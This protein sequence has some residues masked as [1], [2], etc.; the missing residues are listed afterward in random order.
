[1]L[2]KK[3]F[4]LF[5]VGVMLC[6]CQDEEFGFS[7]EEIHQTVVEREYIKAFNA[8]FPEIDPNHT[9][10][11][12]PDT[13][14]EEIM[15]T[16]MTRA[17]NGAVPLVYS[18]NIFENMSYTD[19]QK[20]LDYMKEAEDNRGKCAQDFEYKAIED[21]G[22]G[23]ETYTITPTFWGRKFCDTNWVGIYYIG[24]DGNKY[25]LSSFWN[26]TQ[27]CSQRIKVIYADG[28]VGDMPQSTQPITDDPNQAWN[29]T[30]PLTHSCSACG[31]D[32]KTGWNNNQTCSVCNGTGKAGVDHYELPQFTIKVPVGMK[33]GVY[34]RTQKQQNK[35]TG[36][37]NLETWY[38]N[39]QYNPMNTDGSNTHV[40]A[41]AT[42]TFNGTTYVSF[43]DAPTVCSN[44]NGTG[45]CITCK[46]GHYDHDYNDIVLTIT[47]RPVE[48][49]Y[50]S[51]KYRVMCEDLGGTFDWDFNDVVYDVIYEDGKQQSDKAKVYVLVQAVGGTL[52]IYVTYLGGLGKPAND[53]TRT[54]L[55]TL[56][57]GQTEPNDK[58]LYTPVNV[59]TPEYET[60]QNK[61]GQ[62][63]LEFTLSKQKYSDKELDVR[64][65]VK[66]IS[67][68]AYQNGLDKS[69]TSEV[70]FPDDVGNNIP[71][72]FMTSTG[73]EWADELQNITSKYPRFAKWVASQNEGIAWWNSDPNF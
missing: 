25:D 57:S 53:E 43:E 37:N 21:G 31:G 17:H 16:N 12:T 50:R 8:E 40:K 2:N 28:H 11:C 23:F 30:K 15:P 22:D 18:E 34:L 49:T 41:A 72:C 69:A 33:W 60:I 5:P 59:A 29:E 71:Q 51:I 6:G 9:W 58:G 42:F 36:S 54:E 7:Y 70:N 66:E 65:Y 38:S 52:P 62:K 26:D 63:I 39:S 24:S 19:V 67:I 56:L 27:S 45:E 10:M 1:M 73:T 20:A 13:V 68:K 48:S 61:P 14:Y 3:W 4:V 44:T 46:H 64:D 55:H 35:G 32:G 47:P